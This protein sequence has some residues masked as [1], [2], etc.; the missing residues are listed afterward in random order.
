MKGKAK[1]H[2]TGPVALLDAMCL[3][4]GGLRAH[5]EDAGQ[6]TKCSQGEGPEIR[7]R[8]P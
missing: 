5:P 4:Y 7:N 2:G 1:P 8:N 3:L 6:G